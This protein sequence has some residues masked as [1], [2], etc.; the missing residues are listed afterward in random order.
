MNAGNGDIKTAMTDYRK[1][2]ELDN[3]HAAAWYNQG[4]MLFSQGDF[5]GAINCW[6]HTL[7]VQPSLFRAYN[8]RAAAHV[9]LRNYAAAVEDY[10]TTLE[11]NPAFA[12]AYDNFAWLLAT[13]EDSEFRNPTRAV[14][15]AR[16]ACELTNNEDWSHL[17]TL[18]ASYAEAGDFA[19][20]KKW[21]VESHQLA[22][23]D[24]KPQLMKLVKLYE[25]HINKQRAASKLDEQKVRR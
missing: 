5:K 21:L 12:K 10:E 3:G 18:A 24:Q 17:S 14:S 11:L 25:S 8:N 4:N 19:S 16:R 15:Y 22:P 2:T 20:A 7:A 6:N 23:A 1:A 13:A 9:Q